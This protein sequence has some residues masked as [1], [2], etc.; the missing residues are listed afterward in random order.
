MEVVV[1]EVCSAFGLLASGATNTETMRAHGKDTPIADFSVLASGPQAHKQTN[2]IA[3][4]G[5]TIIETPD[6]SAEIARR[7]QLA[8][9]GYHRYRCEL[10]DKSLKVRMLPAEAVEILL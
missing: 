6:I 2:A 1:K 10:Y 5:A 7:V 9:D 8:R 4:L 3:Y